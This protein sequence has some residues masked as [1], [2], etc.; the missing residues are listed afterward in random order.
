MSAQV[1]LILL[2][3][4]AAYAN[5]CSVP[6]LFDDFSSIVHNPHLAHPWS[7]ALWLTGGRPMTALSFAINYALGGFQVWGYHAV[8]LAL[9]LAAALTLYGVIRR[10]L[11]TSLLRPRWKQ[12]AAGTAFAVSLLWTVHPLQTESVTY[13]VQR[14]ESL[15]GFF[16]LATLYAFIRGAATRRS[17]WRNISVIACALGMLSKPV[18]MTAPVAVWLYDALLLS[19]GW[20]AALRQRRGYYLSLAAT[21]LLGLFCL[22]LAREQELARPHSQLGSMPLAA[23]PLAYA[24]T[25]P[26]VILQYLRLA[27]WP[28]PL[29]LDYLWPLATTTAAIVWPS[30]AIGI[31]V[32]VTIVALIQRRPIGMLGAWIILTLAPSSSV[33]PIRDLA[34]E[35]RMY[36]P[37]A[38]VIAFAV[39]T[40]WWLIGRTVKGPAEQRRLA[41]GLVIGIAAIFTGL[42]MRR[43]ADYRSELSMWQDI[44]AKRPQ[45][46][47]AQNTLGSELLHLG[48]RAEAVSHFEAAIRLKPDYVEA[49]YNL[50]LARMLLGQAEA[51]KAAFH[52]ALELKPD[53]PDAYHNLGVALAGEGDLAG[54]EA[55]YREALR[56]LQQE[57]EAPPVAGVRWV[58]RGDE[59]MTHLALGAVLAR[60][61]RFEEAAAELQAVVRIAPNDPNA[62]YNLGN[63]Y[64]EQG[65]LEDAIAEYRATL[66]LDPQHPQAK[67]NLDLALARVP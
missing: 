3:G 31:F 37:L 58:S 54:A 39:F 48:R 40:A 26:G 22:W 63:V 20:L 42:T 57:K 5:S 32:M 34:A 67:A 10:T 15:M 2:A 17:A 30:A 59:L 56:L 28:H 51:A 18:M 21:W 36:L 11:Q 4:L 61:G 53:L 25:Q 52:R 6:F 14:G 66:R 50:G 45:N 41:I 60:Q 43:N 16:Y 1:I 29:V 65:R 19:P 8:N 62:H 23:T 33:I 27:V 44:I 55:N 38:A 13:I 9:H 64:V 49:Y 35:H 12:E 7:P 47:R 24:A 46:F